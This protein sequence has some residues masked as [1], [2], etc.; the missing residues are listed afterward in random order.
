MHT[1]IRRFNFQDPEVVCKNEMSFH[2]S[3]YYTIV[4][5]ATVGYGMYVYMYVF[6]YV[7]LRMCVCK[8]FLCMHIYVHADVILL[9]LI[10]HD[11]EF[12][13]AL[14]AHATNTFLIAQLWLSHEWIAQFWLLPTVSRS[15]CVCICAHTHKRTHACMHNIQVMWLPSLQSLA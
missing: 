14:F 10:L 4:T 1:Y 11:C 2:D 6:M 5:F 3:L 13:D 8:T 7:C 9:L 15:M 12:C